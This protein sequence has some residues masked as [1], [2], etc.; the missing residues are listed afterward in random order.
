MVSAETPPGSRKRLLGDALFALLLVV[1]VVGLAVS[2]VLRGAASPVREEVN[3]G[4]YGKAGDTFVRLSY[5]VYHWTGNYELRQRSLKQAADYYSLAYEGDGYSYGYGISLALT[6]DAMGYRKSAASTLSR[7]LL[8]AG[9]ARRK[10]LRPVLLL[11]TFDQPQSEWVERADLELQHRDVS[12]LL[13]A[14]AY[15]RIGRDDLAERQRQR[16]V[17]AGL[18]LAPALVT[19]LAV[20]GFVLLWGVVGLGWGAGWLVRRWRRRPKVEAPTAPALWSNRIIA[21]AVIV[22][23]CLQLLVGVVVGLTLGD[24]FHRDLI[25]LGCGTVVSGAGALMWVRCRHPKGAKLGWDFSR[26]WRQLAAGLAAA[27]V[28]VLPFMLLGRVIGSGTHSRPL[29]DPVLS[30]IVGMFGEAPTWLA[31]VLMCAVAPAFEEGLF[32][33]VVYRGLRSR[34]SLLSAAMVSAFVFALAHGSAAS[35]PLMFLLGLM[36]AY[37]C[38]RHQSVFAPAVAHAAFN[39]FSLSMLMFMYGARWPG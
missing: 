8:Q 6:L 27:G 21:E 13:L 5:L 24:T 39:A 3:A 2:L 32:R 11:L 25:L 9:E 29:D 14:D 4:A 17:K 35:L 26:Y 33:G 18:S 7:A 20:C 28:V 22:Y 34:R 15:R 10:E 36:L 30:M 37:L 16:M 31:A 1:A 23:L 38:E 19:M 12:A